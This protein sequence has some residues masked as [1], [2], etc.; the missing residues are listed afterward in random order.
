MQKIGYL[1]IFWCFLMGMKMLKISVIIL[2]IITS[3]PLID[4]SSISRNGRIVA[5]TEK[6]SPFDEIVSIHHLAENGD[7]NPV[8]PSYRHRDFPDRMEIP[9]RSVSE[10]AMNRVK[11]IGKAL[12]TEMSVSAVPTIDPIVIVGDQDLLRQAAI[13]GWQ[14]SGSAQFPITITG[15]SITENSTVKTPVYIK[16]TTL[17]IDFKVNTIHNATNPNNLLNIGGVVLDNVSNVFFYDNVIGSNKEFGVYIVY[18]RNIW[19]IGNTFQYNHRSNFFISDST[20]IRIVNNTFLSTALLVDDYDYYN[21]EIFIQDSNQVMIE[22]NT[23]AKGSTRRGV[24]SVLSGNIT[25]IGNNFANSTQ[26][27]NDEGRIAFENS[28]GDNLIENNTITNNLGSGIVFSGPYNQKVNVVNNNTIANNQ[29]SGI[30]IN[31]GGYA[32]D[33]IPIS[34]ANNSIFSNLGH[35][36]YADK[37]LANSTISSN[38][39]EGNGG[40]GIFLEHYQTLFTM[41]NVSLSGNTVR[42][43]NLGIHFK[44]ME[45]V[46]LRSSVANK[47]KEYGIHLEASENI[48][49][50]SI[51]AEDNGMSGIYIHGDTYSD[52]ANNTLEKIDANRNNES[53]IYVR[54]DFNSLFSITAVANKLYGLYLRFTTNTT[55]GDFLASYNLDK[56]AYL[57]YS[58][59][60]TFTD[61]YI[62]DA[63]YGM[64]FYV[65]SNNAIRRAT[66]SHHTKYGLYVTYSWNSNLTVYDSTFK[67]NTHGIYAT[68]STNISIYDTTFEQTVVDAISLLETES[69]S[70][71]DNTFMSVG[72]SDDFFMAYIRVGTNS[73]STNITQNSIAPFM[74][75]TEL[76]RSAYGVILDGDEATTIARNEFHNSY[77][78]GSTGIY[79]DNSSRYA[80]IRENT[81]TSGINEG[82]YSLSSTNAKIIN[83]TFTVKNTGIAIEG[84]NETYVY[85][86][87]FQRNSFGIAILN[88]VNITITENSFNDISIGGI[89][90]GDS[91][92]GNGGSV[93]FPLEITNNQM[94]NVSTGIELDSFRNVKIIHNDISQA[95]SYGIYIYDSPNVDIEDNLIHH[96]TMAG[97]VLNGSNVDA[98][99]ILRNTIYYQYFNYAIELH[100]TKGVSISENIFLINGILRSSQILDNGQSTAFTNNYWDDAVPFNEDANN[101]GIGDVEYKTEG[102]AGSMDSS[103]LLTPPVYSYYSHFLLE[104]IFVTFPPLTPINGTYRLGWR[105][106]FD[107]NYHSATYSLFYSN[108]NGATFTQIA[109][110]LTGQT[111][112]WDT[113]SLPNGQYR[114]KIVAN[115]G[116]GLTAEYVSNVFNIG[117]PSQQTHELKPPVLL[118]PRG[119]ETLSGTVEIKWDAAVDTFGHA[120]IYSLAISSDGGSTWEI[121]ASELTGTSFMWDTTT[122][123][124]GQYLM[125][126]V[127]DDGNGLTAGDQTP[128]KFTIQNAV[129]TG[130]PT[131]LLTTSSTNEDGSSFPTLWAGLAI[132]IVSISLKKKHKKLKFR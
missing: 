23:F 41:V 58:T 119:G 48:T 81:F 16:D 118:N 34:I 99:S 56:N 43:N 19:F 74:P 112:D 6:N 50:D 91:F 114:L 18:S 72:S 67:N 8:D 65:G 97:I 77:N 53:G 83:N 57:Y 128:S 39:I 100:G 109:S 89:S 82:I 35:G 116:N 38:L 131:S 15:E 25:I 130:S 24:Y 21:A 101:D 94:V 11:E 96:N 20:E 60:G 123:E 63:P 129:S 80:E 4:Y 95:S 52:G 64:Y 85:A 27:V 5:T 115:D 31:P 17:A 36:I 30:V 9:V 70:I 132:I 26:S 40:T 32:G 98:I 87:T 88:G 111:F 55:V 51:A 54:S 44:Y 108:D 79:L 106:A 104:A 59:N 127:A 126:V 29:G 42:S 75:A 47:N 22:G 2:L 93:D 124:N 107:S 13:R 113:T 73:K 1:F 125:K 37:A 62:A 90:I 102:S 49:L 76:L 7:L 68:Y 117:D 86:N 45:G 71:W 46:T 92:F 61:W 12:P 28:L 10:Y 110:S 121:I 78:N 120:I 84:G 33:T 3:F 14:G 122:V 103:P 69:V 105:I 66:I